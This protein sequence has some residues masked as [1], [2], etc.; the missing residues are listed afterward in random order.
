M[1]KFV[2]DLWGCQP[3]ITKTMGVAF[4]FVVVDKISKKKS[5]LDDNF[6]LLCMGS[7]AIT[8][9]LQQQFWG[10]IDQLQTPTQHDTS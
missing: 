1:Q 5:V 10:D 3:Q 9:W 7:I 4:I 6:M 2:S 8:D